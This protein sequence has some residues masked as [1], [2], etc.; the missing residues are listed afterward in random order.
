ML[1]KVETI[2][3]TKYPEEISIKIVK[4]YFKILLEYRKKDWKNCI[5]TIGQFNEAIYRVIEL[6]QS[7]TYIPLAQQLPQFN[8]KILNQW[9]NSKISKSETFR[10]IM[11]RIL[12]GM[13]CLRSKRGAVHLSNID[14]NE[15]DATMLLYQ[16]KW[17]VAELI[18]HSSNLCF[19]ETTNLIKQIIVKENDIVWNTGKRTRILKLIPAQQQ[20]LCLLYSLGNLTDRELFENIEYANFSIFKT[21]VLKSLHKKRFIEYEIPNCILSPLGVCESEKILSVL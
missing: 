21:R 2:L 20:V 1:N 13:Y 3:K 9:E 5:A 11:P 4:L 16:A 15:L 6:E 10:V 12:F 8:S 19:D 7:G 18:R 14:P 17:I